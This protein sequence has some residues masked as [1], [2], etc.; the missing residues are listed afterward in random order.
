VDNFERQQNNPGQ[1]TA[2]FLQEKLNYLGL[3]PK[4]YNEFIVYWLPQ[5]KDIPYNLI[6][7]QSAAYTDNAVLTITPE[8]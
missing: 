8:P 7:F 2:A 6:T 3:T 5:M 1:D 4:E